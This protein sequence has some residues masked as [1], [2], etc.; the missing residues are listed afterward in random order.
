MGLTVAM[1]GS[2]TVGDIQPGWSIQEDATPVNPVDASAGTGIVSLVAKSTDTSKFII[3]NQIT[4][5]HDALGEFNGV[6]TNGSVQ[7]SSVGFNVAPLLSLLVVTK[8]APPVGPLPLSQI[9][10][11]YVALCTDQITVNY[12][13][14]DDPVQ[15]YGGWNA[16]VWYNLKQLAACNK[17]ELSFANSI[18]TV[19][20]LGSSVYE[21]N[22]STPVVF[23]T[24]RASTGR[25]I[26]MVCQNTVLASPSII[27]NYSQNPSLETNATNWS[28]AVYNGTA[29]IART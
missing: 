21:L 7:G 8:V 29:T 15:L 12:Q 24:D 27:T 1:T 11:T 10:Q 14:S 17:V 6:I 13:A 5:S 20:D 9:I 28:N 25:S 3:D 22:D 2:G 26:N 4:V 16:E 18:M 19:S 23:Q